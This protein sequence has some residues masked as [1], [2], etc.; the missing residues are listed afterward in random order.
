MKYC[1]AV[2]LLLENDFLLISSMYKDFNAVHLT[3][4]LPFFWYSNPLYYYEERMLQIAMTSIIFRRLY[5]EFSFILCTVHL[6]DPFLPYSILVCFEWFLWVFCI[7]Q[8]I[9]IVK[10][11]IFGLFSTKFWRLT[12]CGVRRKSYPLGCL[13]FF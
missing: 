13:Y 6:L 12:P 1:I 7:L 10:N 9:K 3:K 11:W 8:W 4:S 5:T 2:G